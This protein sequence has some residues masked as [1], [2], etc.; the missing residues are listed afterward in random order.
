MAADLD[1][2]LAAHAARAWSWGDVDCSMVLADWAIACGHAD[3]AAALRGSYAD[4]LGW[5]RIVVR[6]GGL[7]PLVNDVC[8]RAGF[9]LVTGPARGVVGVIG[10][11]RNPERQWGAIH[12]GARWQV[13]TV[14]GFTP[15]TAQTLGLWSV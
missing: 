2:F 11:I 5:K 3:P 7:L 14:E 13:R 6:R 10:S 15:M 12:D 9:A 4:E 1:A 8:A